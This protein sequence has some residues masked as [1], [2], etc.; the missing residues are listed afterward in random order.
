MYSKCG[1]IDAARVLFDA[2]SEPN[3]VS[4]SAMIGAY[5]GHGR[6]EEA[7]ALFEQMVGEA[8]IAPDA[9]TFTAVLAACSHGG[10]VELGRKVFGMMEGSF[11]IRPRLEHYT[12]MVDLLGRAG[13]VEEAERLLLGMK[14]VPDAALW[15]AL[16]GTCRIHG[17]V[18]VAERLAKRLCELQ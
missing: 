12:C 14:L 2:M 1:C 10:N 15:G 11:G 5:G 9:M 8:G 17:K 13:E 18:E 6:S 3:V 16:L 7:V 4:W